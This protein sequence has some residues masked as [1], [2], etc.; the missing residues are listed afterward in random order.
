MDLS[1]WSTLYPRQD[2]KNRAPFRTRFVSFSNGLWEARQ[3]VCTTKEPGT[4]IT[5]FSAD[6]IP[7]VFTTEGVLV[8]HTLL[9]VRILTP[10]TAI[11]FATISFA[12][13]AVRRATNAIVQALITHTI[14]TCAIGATA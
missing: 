13:S 12:S 4:F 11:A 6:I 8:A 2:T 5:K 10:D 14:A 9:N 1:D 7:G 3:D